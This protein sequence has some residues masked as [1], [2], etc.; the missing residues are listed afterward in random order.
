LRNP[1]DFRVGVVHGQAAQQSDG[2][3][4]GADARLRPSQRH[5]E[6]GQYATFEPQQQICVG[7]GIVAG[8]AGRRMDWGTW[9]A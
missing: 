6:V 1:G 9:L 8:D 3:L 4:V 7:V 2:V 5:G